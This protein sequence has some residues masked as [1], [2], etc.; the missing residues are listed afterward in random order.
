MYSLAHSFT[1]LMKRTSSKPIGFGSIVW[2]ICAI[3][4]PLGF[5]RHG[6]GLEYSSLLPQHFRRKRLL[7][8]LYSPLIKP[9]VHR[10]VD[11]KARKSRS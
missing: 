5:D 11:Y 7:R 2:D 3:A 4:S 8:Q 6:T 10:S 9:A 1:A